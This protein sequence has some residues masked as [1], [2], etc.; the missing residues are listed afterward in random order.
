M[1]NQTV[2]VPFVGGQTLTAGLYELE[3]DVLVEAASSVTNLTLQN[4]LYEALFTTTPI[5]TYRLVIFVPNDNILPPP[6]TVVA[7]GYFYVQ[8]TG[9]DKIYNVYDQVI[10]N[11]ESIEAINQHTTY[12]ASQVIDA[13]T[14][15]GDQYW[16]TS[17]VIAMLEVIQQTLNDIENGLISQDEI[18]QAIITGLKGIIVQPET[19]VLGGGCCPDT[20]PAVF[21][22]HPDTSNIESIK[23]EIT[24]VNNS[25]KEVIPRL[26]PIAQDKSIAEAFKKGKFKP[27]DQ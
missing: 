24:K 11:N 20:Q 13:I 10:I 18:Q 17:T 14:S 4:N 19:K 9:E 26:K 27:L 6:A 22:C 1:P 21:P 3:D 8:L 7:V 15:H 5:G 23:S 25:K 2:L 12:E 16:S